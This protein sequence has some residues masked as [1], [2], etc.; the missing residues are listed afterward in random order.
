[1]CGLCS[2]EGRIHGTTGANAP[3]TAVFVGFGPAFALRFG[4]A[5]RAK[6]NANVG[7]VRY[8]F[9]KGLNRRY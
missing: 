2:F 9:P 6:G 1:M 5:E 3:E 8:G 7:V 4:N